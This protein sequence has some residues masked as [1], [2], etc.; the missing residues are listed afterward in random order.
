ME[1]EREALWDCKAESGKDGVF[2]FQHGHAIEN[3]PGQE[4]RGK[5]FRKQG[6]CLDKT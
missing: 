6:Q 1:S 5:T 4:E 2:I 3:R